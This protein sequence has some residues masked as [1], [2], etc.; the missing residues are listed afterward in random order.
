MKGENLKLALEKKG[1]T[2]RELAEILGCSVNTVWRWCND[3]QEVSDKIK[4]KLSEILNVPVSYLMGESEDFFLKIYDKKNL[5]KE[6]SSFWG[7][8]EPALGTNF[9]DVVEDC[10]DI[11]PPIHDKLPQSEEFP[12]NRIIFETG[13]GENKKRYIL[14]TTPE[15]YDFL[16]QLH[17]KT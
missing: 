11:P 14:P 8:T 6:L 3:K 5:P 2:Q 1:T 7:V 4:K 9:P 12:D 13:I 15:S 10:R 16:K 17:N